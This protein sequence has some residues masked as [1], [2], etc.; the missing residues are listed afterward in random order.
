[1]NRNA[2]IALEIIVVIAAILWFRYDYRM[3]P[4]ALPESNN[5][6]VPTPQ[7]TRLDDSTTPVKYDISFENRAHHEALVTVTFSDLQPQ[8][9]ELRMSRTSPGRYALH[10]F[11]KNVYDVRA[12]NGKGQQLQISRANPH[13]WN[14]AGHDGTVTVTYTIFGDRAGGTYMGVDNS[15]AHLNIPATFMWARGYHHRPVEI[16]FRIPDKKWTIATQLAPTSHKES[17]SE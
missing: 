11:A 9:L 10:E 7:Q 3:E 14:V 4:V 2:R 16:R 15:H 8:P 17:K 1:M 13:Q 5:Q 6:A 12:V